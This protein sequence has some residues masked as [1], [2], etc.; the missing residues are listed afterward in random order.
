MIVQLN[1]HDLGLFYFTERIGL[2]EYEFIYKFKNH[3]TCP[4]RDKSVKRIFCTV[5]IPLNSTS[6][7]ILAY[8][9]SSSNSN[10]L[11]LST[12]EPLIQVVNPTIKFFT[13]A[14][15]ISILEFPA[16]DPI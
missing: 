10:V 7:V 1:K 15:S 3:F 4:V 11:I 9:L 13:A 16:E 5:K 6:L 8:Q 12:S 14:I 2:I